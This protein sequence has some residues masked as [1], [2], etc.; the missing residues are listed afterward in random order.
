[1]M[2]KSLPV[3]LSVGAF[4][5]LTYLSIYTN[6]WKNDAGGTAVATGQ[7]DIADSETHT[8]SLDSDSTTSSNQVPLLLDYQRMAGSASNQVAI[9]VENQAGEVI[10]T[11]SVSRFTAQGGFSRRPDSLNHWVSAVQASQLSQQQ[12][13]LVTSPTPSTGENTY[14]WDGKTDDG[15]GLEDGLYTIYL[16][17]TLYWESNVLFQQDIVLEN[18][19]F[20]L[21]GDL[22]SVYSSDD[23]FNKEMI[24]G[25]SVNV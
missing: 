18:G 6:F 10:R 23:S 24:Q 1:M 5:I 9:W 19:V 11:L 2:K 25:V 21:V 12:L 13:D 15:L 20:S 17:G 4:T 16:E 14:I 3:W 8:D 22:T 7:V